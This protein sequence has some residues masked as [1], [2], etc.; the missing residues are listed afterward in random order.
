[1]TTPSTDPVIQLRGL[2]KTYG[3][4][5]A[6]DG[7]SVEV[8]S[9]AV[10]L[11]G[12]NGA[13]KTTLIKLLLGLLVPTR[14]EARIGGLDP[15]GR[16]SRLAIRRVVG[17][18]PEGDCLLP[19]MSGVELV[20]TL[21]RITGLSK[22]DAMTRAHEVLDYV[23]LDEERYRML[24]EYSTGM[25]QRLKLAQTLVH[26]PD[27]LLLDEPTNGLDP[28]GR[29]HM[30]ELVHDLGHAQGK[31]ILLCSHL[32]PDVEQTC[33][34][35]VVLDR[36]RLCTSGAIEAMTASD[37]VQMAV[38]L[39]DPWEP[40]ARR[41][42]TEGFECEGEGRELRLRLP[43]NVRDADHLFVLAAEEG[44]TITGL[45]EVRS[46]LQDVFLEALGLPRTQMAA[47]ERP[48]SPGA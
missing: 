21:G 45:R 6:L 14:G 46:S 36:G 27:I 38:T 7:V 5:R 33:D 40:L 48:E 31:N 42:A 17:Y 15:V 2:V 22:Q 24:D 43:Q 28:K 39:G 34:H 4:V 19:G 12:P 16:R 11:L 3:A 1:M 13:G 9:G 23:E 25:K 30:L 35:V 20:S 29:R 8:P 10:G 26:D 37:S 41:F 47:L 32:L 18:M 44:V